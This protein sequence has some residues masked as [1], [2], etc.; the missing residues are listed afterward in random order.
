MPGLQQLKQFNQDILNLGDEVTIRASRGEK[1]S[2]KPIPTDVEDRND[3]EDFVLGLPEISEEELA[4][5]DAAAAEK[6]KEANDFS[7]ITG[8]KEEKSSAK[9]DTPAKA[10]V[11]DVSDLL[12]SV[13]GDDADFGD[14]DLSEFEEPEKPKEPPKP[15][16]V[17]IED[18]DLDALLAPTSKKAPEPEPIPEPIPVAPQPAPVK[19]AAPKPA[20]PE[21]EKSYLDELPPELQAIMG[22]GSKKQEE[23]KK[24][25]TEASLADLG[26]DLSSS[27]APT[28]SAS[29]IPDLPDF[30]AMDFASPAEP[31][32]PAPDAIPDIEN[33]SPL[34]SAIPDL[35]EMPSG[36]I[37]AA[38]IP[39][40]DSFDNL[41]SFDDIPEVPADSFAAPENI[42]SFDDIPS[43]EDAAAV[44]QLPAFEDIPSFD[45]IP[46]GNADGSNTLAELN[47]LPSFD[48]P[49]SMESVPSFDNFPT[50]KKTAAVPTME[51]FGD[52]TEVGLDSFG[53]EEDS[54]PNANI[55]A[56]DFSI[57]EE[58]ADI[59]M[60][61]SVPDFGADSGMDF[62]IDAGTDTDFGADFDSMGSADVDF[63]S[64]IPSE[65]TGF[66]ENAPTESFDT[67]AID[68]MD[69]SNN[70]DTGGESD[71]AL[72]GFGDDGDAFNIPGF[73]DTATAALNKNKPQVSTPDFSG[74][75]MA[76]AGKPKNTFTDAEYEKFNKNLA[77][78]PL[79]VR[80][81]LEDLVVKNEFTDDA[82]FE[83]LEK[84]L[85]KVPARQ[86]ASELEKMLDISIDVPR[87]YERR[88]AEEYEAYKKS[89]EYQL[90]NKI[91]PGAIISAGAAILVFCLYVIIST[92][93]VKPAT[94]THYYKKGWACLEREEYPQSEMEFN[95]ALTYKPMKKWFFKY[96][97]GYRS[98]KQ[99]ER[100]VVMYRAVLQRF[101]HDKQAGLNWASMELND[102]YNYTEVERI[103]KR[104]VLD[105]YINDA[106]ALLLLGDNYLEWATEK[107]PEKF[108]SAMEQYQILM[109]LYG[110][111]KQD[112][113][114][115]R[116]MRYYIRK[117][118]LRQVLQYKEYFFPRK[119]A[120]D[121]KDLTELSGYLFDKRYGKLSQSEEPLRILIE[122]VRTLLERAV[123][124]DM[125]NPVAIYNFGRYFVETANYPSALNL[126]TNAKDIFEAQEV[127]N[128]RDTYK[129]I[130]THRLIGEL[131]LDAKKRIQA[132]E[133]F[134]S[135]INLF[136]AENESSGFESDENIG[137]MYSDLADINYFLAGNMDFAKTNYIKAINNKYDNAS[138]RY[139]VGYIQY[140]DKEYSEALG[141]FIR[142]ADTKSDDTHLLLALANTLSLRNDNYAA[143]G[144]YEKLI[145]SLNRERA[146]HDVLLP[147]VRED[148]ADIVETYLKATN[149][150]GVTQSRI[151][152]ATGN[153][154][155]N[156]EAIVNLTESMRAWDA[157]TRN[158]ISMERLEGSNLPQ[159]NILYISHPSST[160]SPEIFTA[161][162]RTLVGEKGL[163]E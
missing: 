111:D 53:I 63:T 118:D 40:A 141:S 1:P 83:I 59:P 100:S 94:A 11:P 84:V 22:G 92:L 69:F 20:E 54:L 38:E 86:L 39:A 137:K 51:S 120:L 90:K 112:L 81:A 123:K 125:N 93:I 68:D 26:I 105:Y 14:I 78:Y 151:A 19:Q 58:S 52:T 66:D 142:A 60:E 82:V 127:R 161:I 33:I 18:M 32:S 77:E 7:D 57:Q 30:G 41:P 16:E 64:D 146:L 150:L 115:S 73:S 35:P 49:E 61:D 147:Q 80:I 129:Y 98:H 162:S 4:Q 107:D 43:A 67:S 96:A 128:K 130:N 149:N 136:E 103:L 85:K 48:E 139:R 17:A 65:D 159:Q 133:S 25:P 71:F 75:K 97:E 27:P 45:D 153:S 116:M 143:Q 91:I 134:V 72:G 157:L 79:N 140:I 132:E 2:S 88:T 76:D 104:E 56:P 12:S 13:G 34:D 87:D 160:Y 158:Q 9:K 138:I 163:E 148:Q 126:L 28:S 117:D 37:P 10:N 24:D 47:D 122:D 113:Y 89:L 6:A 108:D 55:T 144:Y 110:E 23:P 15:K 102:R 29:A 70:P 8:D 99:Y 124:A 119:K 44:D 31:V 121:S 5:A 156:A 154:K 36:E 106:D 42:P 101:N 131:Y 21:P 95:T 62:G 109:Q 3:T 152:F 114:L 50:G 74:A 155:L 145:N 46:D 135:G